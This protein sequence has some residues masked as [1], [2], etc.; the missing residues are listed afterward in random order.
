MKKF[1]KIQDS[2]DGRY[3]CFGYPKNI[4]DIAGDH[5]AHEWCSFYHQ[6]RYIIMDETLKVG[7]LFIQILQ[8]GDYDANN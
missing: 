5:E 1:Y 4:N 2:D 7:F 3:L 8:I 6:R